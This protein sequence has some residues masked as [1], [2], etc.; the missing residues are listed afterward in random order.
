MKDEGLAIADEKWKK[1]TKHYD[2]TQN[3][4]LPKIQQI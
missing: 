2:E 3:Y 1:W 4:Y